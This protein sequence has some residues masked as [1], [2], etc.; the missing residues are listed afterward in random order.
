MTQREVAKKCGWSAN[1]INEILKGKKG[2]NK[3]TMQKIREYYPNLK[4]KEILKIR[5]KVEILGD[6]END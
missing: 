6:K 4:W 3:E 5:Y 2:C 1:Y